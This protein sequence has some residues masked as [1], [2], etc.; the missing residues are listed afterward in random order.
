[1]QK[2]SYRLPTGLLPHLKSSIFTTYPDINIILYMV[3]ADF[4]ALQITFLQKGISVAKGM[5]I[6]YM[7]VV[8]ICIIN[9]SLGTEI[10]KWHVFH[11]PGILVLCLTL[12]TKLT[13]IR[14]QGR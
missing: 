11:L 9:T 4:Q 1:M 6:F 2:W 13:Q 10:V 12:L 8:L 3:Q 5:E 7:Q 14:E